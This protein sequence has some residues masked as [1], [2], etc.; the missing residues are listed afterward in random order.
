MYPAAVRRI[1]VY[2]DEELDE[3]TAR[4]AARRGISKAALIRACLSAALGPDADPI[5]GLVGVSDAEPA[6]DVDAIVYGR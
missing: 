1:N 2:I 6:D 4:E 5:D 3:R